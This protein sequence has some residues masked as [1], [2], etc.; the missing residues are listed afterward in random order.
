MPTRMPQMERP[1]G[2]RSPVTASPH[3]TDP[4]APRQA[5]SRSA[6]LR[7]H[8]P[9]SPSD[10]D[11]GSATVVSHRTEPAQAPRMEIATDTRTGRASFEDWLFGR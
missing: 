9:L 8:A 10:A 6:P 4:N 7:L 2:T 1:D 5:L 3:A 11:S